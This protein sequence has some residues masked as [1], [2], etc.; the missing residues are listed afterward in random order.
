MAKYRMAVVAAL[1]GLGVLLAV[2]GA[3]YSQQQAPPPPDPQEAQ[4][5]PQDQADQQGTQV[6]ARGPI[7]EAYAEPV[8]ANPQPSQVEPKQPPAP[9]EELPPDQKPAGDNVQWIPGYWSWDN[10]RN[11]F[12][13]VSGIW[14]IPPPGRQWVPGHW[15]QAEGGWQWTPGFWGTLQQ[16]DV[17]YLPPPPQPPEAAPSTPAPDDNSVYIPGTYV[18]QDTRYLWRPG[19][20]VGYRPGWVWMPAHYIWTPAGY[21]FVDG[22]WDFEFAR[23]GL[24]FA[25]V[26]FTRPLW[27]QP[28]WVYQPTYAVSPDFVLAAMFVRPNY[29]S[30]YFGDYFDAG[31]RRNGF[32][33]W[34]NYRFGRYGYDPLFTYYRWAH[35]D[36]PVWIQ[37]LRA[38]YTGRIRGDIPRPPRTFVRNTVVNNNIVVN[39]INVRNVNNLTAIAPLSQ[40]GRSVVRLQPITREQ[41]VQEQHVAK[42]LVQVSQQR[43]QI[44]RQLVTKGTAPREGGRAPQVVR[45]NL[46]H[47]PE[48]AR[49]AERFQPPPPP[50]NYHAAARP[51]PG[52]QPGAEPRTEGRRP[53]ET[54]RPELGR[55]PEET[56][57]PEPGRVPR[58]T[59][60]AETRPEPRRYPGTE[61][62]PPGQPRP[63]PRPETRP[64]AEPRRPE[65]RPPMNERPQTQPRPEARPPQQPRPEPRPEPRPAAQPRPEPR[66]PMNERPQAQPRPEPR[67]QPQPRPEARPPQQPRPEPRPEP[68]PAAQPRP[69]TRPQP[70][71]RPEPKPQP[72]PEPRPPEHPK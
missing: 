5:A 38:V 42:Q 2:D 35:R 10:D 64:G 13:W 25:P 1:L 46:P 9:I 21:V 23:R 57:R 7:H 8:N 33:P 32:V 4:A 22:Y 47:N 6:Q 31:Y 19:Y 16:N 29:F 65:P 69:E 45:L 54:A 17:E 70:Q 60:R 68:R 18:Y 27:R 20:W 71:P 41:R 37:D 14:R 67:P 55:R 51:S 52:R 11:D 61:A 48:A 49:A 26:Y 36:N 3:G 44:E 56:T 58:P 50:V 39:N 53:Q 12:V 34:V 40:F 62:A 63:Q 72:R 28:G 66:P 43:G 15:D 24:L 59:D 30:Y